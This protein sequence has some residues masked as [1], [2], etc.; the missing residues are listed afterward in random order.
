MIAL[1]IGVL[2]AVT[3]IGSGVAGGSL[4]RKAAPAL[5]LK[6]RVAVAALLGTASIWIAG[7]AAL[8][9]MLAWGLSG[10]SQLMPG[11]AGVV[12]QRCLDAANPLPPGLAVDTFIPIVVLLAVPVLLGLIMFVSGY[13]YF[14]RS[15]KQ[16]RSL[17]QAL[18]HT[19]YRTQLVGQD[20]TVIEHSR[21]TAFALAN[22]HWGIVVSTALLELLTTDELAAVV[23]H[24]AAH[25]RQRHHIILRLF[26]GAISALR[27]IPLID[28]IA[29]AIPH[30]LEMAADNAARQHTSTPIMASALLKLGEKSGPGVIHDECDA[31][32][33]HAAGTDR[34]RHLI[35]PPN[36]KLG[37]ASMSVMGTVTGILLT[38]SLVV[39]LPYLRAILDGCLL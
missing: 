16:R 8:G 18:R 11:N 28:A 33:L 3:V 5:M 4:I 37:L 6:P 19:A 32:A 24:E 2:L 34:I 29:S 23:T 39:H 17:E 20:V 14:R 1:I 25:L 22:R 12:C 26:H 31:I 36:G 7:F 10:P 13:R 27:W 30:Y 35:A 9:P 15:A 38:G 21:P